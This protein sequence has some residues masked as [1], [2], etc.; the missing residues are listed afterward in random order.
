MERRST[1]KRFSKSNSIWGML[2]VSALLLTLPIHAFAKDVDYDGTEFSVRVEPGEPTQIS[3]DGD[4]NISRW[5]HGWL[6]LKM[7]IFAAKRIKLV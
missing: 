3:F 7:V 1:M 6:L 2:A 5:K 4:T